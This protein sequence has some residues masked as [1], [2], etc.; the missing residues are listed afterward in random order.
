MDD[1]AGVGNFGLDN[2]TAGA[3]E[4]GQGFSQSFDPMAA[5]EAAFQDFGGFNTT[6]N[7]NNNRVEGKGDEQQPFVEGVDTNNGNGEFL[8]IV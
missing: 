4:F 1:N 3:T 8:L 2:N 7:D 5:A 6:D